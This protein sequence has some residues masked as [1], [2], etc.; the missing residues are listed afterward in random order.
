MDFRTVLTE[1]LAAFE[2]AG[3]RYALIGGLALAL[4]GVPRATVAIDFLIE[5]EDLPRVHVILTDLGY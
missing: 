4:G 2:K 1:L 5:Q 3:V